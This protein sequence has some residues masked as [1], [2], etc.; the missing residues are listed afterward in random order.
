MK[1]EDAKRLFEHARREF[2]QKH[3][4]A[5]VVIPSELD[6]EL[7]TL[8]ARACEQHGIERAKASSLSMCDACEGFSNSDDPCAEC[9]GTGTVSGT[10]D[11]P[12]LDAEIA[13]ENED[14]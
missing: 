11:W 10:L 1:A 14:G 8:F 6:G 5:A 9:G 13:K 2:E 4:T 12:A 3:P 7:L